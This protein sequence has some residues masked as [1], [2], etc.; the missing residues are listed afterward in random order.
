MPVF[1]PNIGCPPA[2]AAKPTA[3]TARKMIPDRVATRWMDDDIVN[4]R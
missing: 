3:L 4:L 2:P 1:M